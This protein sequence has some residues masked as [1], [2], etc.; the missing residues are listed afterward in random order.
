MKDWSTLSCLHLEMEGHWSCVNL[1]KRF[2]HEPC[3]FI[4][5]CKTKKCSLIL[6]FMLKRQITPKKLKKSMS[7]LPSHDQWHSYENICH[8]FLT[9]HCRQCHG[10]VNIMFWHIVHCYRLTC[11][12]QGEEGETGAEETEAGEGTG[13]E[14][15]IREEGEEGATHVRI[16]YVINCS[17]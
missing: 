14:E 9:L 10:S 11:M 3:P 8:R 2:T 12:F 5:Q 1:V 15:A 4:S 13:A 17:I 16:T 6:I 7:I